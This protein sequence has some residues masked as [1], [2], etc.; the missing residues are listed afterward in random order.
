MWWKKPLLTLL[1]VLM[2]IPALFLFYTT[3]LYWNFCSDCEFLS[4][5]QEVVHQLLWRTSFYIHISGGM[6]SLILGPINFIPALRTRFPAFH[7]K[8]GKLYVAA[9]LLLGAPAGLYMAFFAN[10]GFWA[11]I[12]FLL[13]S[14]L[15][16]W[17]TTKAIQSARKRQFAEHRAW[18]IRS[19]AITFA[20]VTLR[21]WVPLLSLNTSIPHETIVVLT[22]WLSWIPNLILA[23]LI[24]RFPYIL[25]TMFAHK[26]MQHQT[27][28]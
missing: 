14:V 27:I 12:G 25:K 7:R 21:I 2:T 19:Y 3:A 24:L 15:W 8:T 5:K 28:P 11:S 23:E 17:S 26:P 9:I 18:M 20:A 16:F 6:L 22:A 13:L 10:G 1:W 4:V